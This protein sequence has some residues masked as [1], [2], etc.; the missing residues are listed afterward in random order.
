MYKL[1]RSNFLFVALARKGPGEYITGKIVLLGAKV[2][3]G[4]KRGVKG[5]TLYWYTY[6]TIP[7]LE[8]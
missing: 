3:K 5:Q 8:S 4:Q 6:L 1:I 7:Y 2:T